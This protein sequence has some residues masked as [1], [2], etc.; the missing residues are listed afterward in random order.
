M[1]QIHDFTGISWGEEFAIDAPLTGI[2]GTITGQG[3]LA[4][5]DHILLCVKCKVEEVEKYRDASDIWQARISVEMPV[6][7]EEM[8]E[9]DPLR[10]VKMLLSKWR[11]TLQQ[12]DIYQRIEQLFI[13]DSLTQVSSRNRFETRLVDEW[14]RMLR[15]QTPLSIVVSAI[16]GMDLYEA[17]HGKEACDRCL[18][19]IAQT[20]QNCAQRSYDVVARYEEHKFAVL[21]PNTSTEGAKYITEQIRTQVEA[22]PVF[23]TD[24]QPPIALRL[25]VATQA[26]DIEREAH[27][28]TRAALKSLD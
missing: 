20:I 13:A 6:S 11:G 23:Q 5:G 26:P 18:K 22:L 14:K 27:D 19:E 25:A 17:T 7:I 15:E 1:T 12:V 2:S 8:T 24:G 16:D 10:P 21:L 9:G 28:L 4:A 3:E